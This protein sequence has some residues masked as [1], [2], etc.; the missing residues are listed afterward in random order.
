MSQIILFFQ[1][2][3][4]FCNEKLAVGDWVH[5][6][7]EGKVNMTQE[8]MRIKWGVGQLVWHCPTEPIVLPLWHVGMEHIL[9]NEPPYYP[10]LGKKVKIPI[11][12]K[13]QC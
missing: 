3:L 5:V 13:Y 7:P 11:L 2:A 6:F 1:E 4:T 10:H 9:P 12:I 8:P